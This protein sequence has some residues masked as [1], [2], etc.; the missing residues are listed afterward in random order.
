[1]YFWI[2]N[3]I[4]IIFAGRLA[5]VPGRRRYRPAV[6]VARPRP[7]REGNL[8]SL[9]KWSRILSP[10]GRD[11]D[12]RSSSGHCRHPGQG[13]IRTSWAVV[14]RQRA[15]KR[16]EDRVHGPDRRL[17]WRRRGSRLGSGEQ[18][19]VPHVVPPR[20]QGATTVGATLSGEFYF[21][22]SILISL[23]ILFIE[24][25]INKLLVL[26]LT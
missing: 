10:P 20:L 12:P 23:I 26:V 7:V 11:E 4:L 17:G 9:F 25:W 13:D 14:P 22:F 3:L 1:M 24:C 18:R 21:N 8:A 19:G 2:I 5:A 6:G 15:C 16:L